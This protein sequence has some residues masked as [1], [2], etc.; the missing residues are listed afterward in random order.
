MDYVSNVIRVFTANANDEYSGP[1]KK[2]MQDKFEFLGIKSPL[3]KEISEPFLS[4]NELP[5]FAN[6]NKVITN[7]WNEPHREYQYLALDIAEKFSHRFEEAEID[8]YEYLV[9]N[10][11]WWDTVDFI[12]T[13]L[14][15][16]H[17]TRFPQLKDEFIDS[18]LDSRNVWLQRCALIFQL[19]YKEN[20]DV[21]TLEK[22]ISV[23]KESSDF[24]LCKAIGW[25]LR[26]YYK[27]NPDYVK[28]FIGANNLPSLSK[29]EALKAMSA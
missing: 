7:L 27:T 18:W 23:C 20:T 11:S 9:V 4:E 26:E 3:R 21:G 2:Y 29:K 14:I 24:F 19:K 16:T 5:E 8:L 22:S 25:A 10:K 17:F 1:M 6:A 28:T 13:N 15:G 12:A